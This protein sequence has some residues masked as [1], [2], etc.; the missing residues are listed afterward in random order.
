MPL[1]SGTVDRLFFI[2]LFFWQYISSHF[3]R[4]SKLSQLFYAL[5][6]GK[7]RLCPI[8]KH[9]TLHYYTTFCENLLEEIE[10]IQRQ[11]KNNIYTQ[12]ALYPPST[13]VSTWHISLN[14]TFD[15]LLLCN[16]LFIFLVLSSSCTPI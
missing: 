5:A 15:E 1:P 2:I 12:N 14:T 13:S 6:L 7:S 8:D 3:I 10:K 9:T 4:I 11:G 16:N